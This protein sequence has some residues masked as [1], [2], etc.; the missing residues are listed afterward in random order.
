[1]LDGQRDSKCREVMTSLSS[2]TKYQ[3]AHDLRERTSLRPFHQ[4]TLTSPPQRE[5]AEEERAR[6]QRAAAR[7]KEQDDAEKARK[8]ALAKEKLERERAMNRPSILAKV[9]LEEV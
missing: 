5:Q 1:V 3:S 7:R 4:P 2:R 9:S 6:L 8:A